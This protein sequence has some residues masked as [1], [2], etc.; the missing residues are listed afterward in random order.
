MTLEISACFSIN[1]H[2]FLLVFLTGTL[3]NRFSWTNWI[4]S[5]KYDYP[6]EMRWNRRGF[7]VWV[8]R[9][10]AGTPLGWYGASQEYLAVPTFCPRDVI[11]YYWSANCFKYGIIRSIHQRF[12]C[13]CSGCLTHDDNF[14][15]ISQP[16]LRQVYI[17]I[18]NQLRPCSIS[19]RMNI[20][21][22]LSTR[23]RCN[24]YRWPPLVF[25]ANSKY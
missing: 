10:L 14:A 19:L 22:V 18:Y 21:T 7:G 5:T 17:E 24:K 15:L 6:E 12:C 3:Q 25:I 8:F 11:G 4:F 23:G 16:S 20:F 2:W 9:R 13:C 1:R